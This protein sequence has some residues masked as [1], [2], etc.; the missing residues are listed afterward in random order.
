MTHALAHSDLVDWFQFSL[1]RHQLG[2]QFAKQLC[3][4][5]E[6][7]GRSISA[8]E[9]AL[10]AHDAGRMV[11]PADLIKSE[12]EQLGARGLAEIAEDVEFEARDCVDLHLAP[13]SLIEL[14]VSLREAF[15]EVDQA[16]DRE[17]NPLVHRRPAG[18]SEARLQA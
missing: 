10:R 16:F 8:I 14:V 11:G 7:G 4:F 3:Y 12:A 6:D 17:T 5:R 1:A 9:D 2:A 15:D 13:D 18:H